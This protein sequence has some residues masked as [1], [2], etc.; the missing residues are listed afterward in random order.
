MNNNSKIIRVLI[1]ISALFLALLTYLL[2]LNLFK[3]D[4]L[5]T[6]SYN[7][8]QWDE[9]RYVDR[10]NIY[11][12]NGLLLA[13]S[14]TDENGTKRVYSQGNIYSHVIGYCSPVYGKSQLEMEFDRELLARDDIGIFAGSKKR[15]FDL[16]LTVDNSFQKYV[17]GQMNGKKGAAVAMNPQTGEILAMVSLPDFQPE[18]QNLEAMW[19]DIVE[20]QDSPLLNRATQGLYPPGSTYKIVTAAAAYENGMKGKSFEDVGYF[21]ADKLKIENYNNKVYGS[22]K[23]EDAFSVSSNQV[24]A[25]IGYQLGT[26]KMQNISERFGINSKVRFDLP[27]ETSR[28]E[29]GKMVSADCAMIGIGQGQ[30]RVTPLQMAVICSTVANGGRT[31]EPYVVAS[32]TK[33][34]VIISQHKPRAANSVISAECAEYLEEMMIKTV[35]SGTGTRAKI[36]GV[37]VAGKTG[38]AENETDMDHAWFV[39]YAPAENPQIAVAVILENEGASGGD[40]AAPVAGRIMKEYLS[41]AESIYE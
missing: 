23:L 14:V 7:R 21:Q 25:T 2:Y 26:E 13:E 3:S 8:R 16:N 10:G 15:G 34:D 24:F 28:I 6:N 40:A 27:T 11:D 5:R 32:V 1:V 33:D 39:G 41:R 36:S 31:I 20:D 4:E 17:Y 19:T 29:Y 30:L 37:T 9:E 35:E 38:T 12:S 18:S 22:I